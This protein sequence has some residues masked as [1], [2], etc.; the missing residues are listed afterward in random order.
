M[1]YNCLGKNEYTKGKFSLIPLRA[2]DMLLIGKWRN[3]QIDVLRQNRYLTDK[4]QEFYYKHVVEKSFFEQEP[5][6]ILFSYLCSGA[7][8]GYGGLTNISWE[9]GRAEMSFLLET[10][11]THNPRLYGQYFSV[12]LALLKDVAFNEL[13]FNRI[14]T[15]TYDIRPVHVEILEKNDFVLEGR[16]REHL[17]VKG[18]IIDS[19]IHGCLKK[20]HDF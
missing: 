16:M 17:T 10:L 15:E 13:H 1:K 9:F 14:F 6:V 8:V 20:T 5:S 4:D 7:C 19:L 3:E 2:K 12:F 11:F 18:K